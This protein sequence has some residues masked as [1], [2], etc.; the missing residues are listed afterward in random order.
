[1]NLESIKQLQENEELP[2]EITRRSKYLG[3]LSINNFIAIPISSI[4]STISS[5]NEIV[6]KNPNNQ[7]IGYVLYTKKIDEVA[8]NQI[9]ELI[10]ICY[11]NELEDVA[12][13]G[14]PFKFK[15]DYIIIKRGHYKEYLEKFHYT[16]ALWGGYVTEDQIPDDYFEHK[17]VITE[18]TIPHEMELSNSFLSET[19]ING[20]LRI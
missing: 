12:E 20:P 1:M 6:I 3:R 17:K 14:L 19:S 11:L 10:F 7:E 18:I 2:H 8:L 15:S 16:S 5:Q 9:S 13:Y 4:T